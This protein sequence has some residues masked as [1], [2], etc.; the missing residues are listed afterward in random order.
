MNIYFQNLSIGVI[1]FYLL[2]SFAISFGLHA[3]IKLLAT[4]FNR[5]FQSKYLLLTLVVFF[6]LTFMVFLLTDKPYA[7]NR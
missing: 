1:V 2:V 6:F 5:K 4:I 3:I 7:G